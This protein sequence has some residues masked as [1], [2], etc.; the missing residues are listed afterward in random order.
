MLKHP[1]SGI[2]DMVPFQ[3]NLNL[4]KRTVESERTAKRMNQHLY[5]SRLSTTY[6]S[7][8]EIYGQLKILFKLCILIYDNQFPEGKKHVLEKL[9]FSLFDAKRNL[10]V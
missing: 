10:L 6:L 9:P 7:I 5:R 3:T 1:A 8:H 2:S 4:K